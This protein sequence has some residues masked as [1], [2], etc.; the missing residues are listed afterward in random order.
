MRAWLKDGWPLLAGG[1]TAMAVVVGAAWQVSTRIGD[2][3]TRLHT[4]IGNVRNEVRDV[5]IR[6]QAE[7]G[8]VRTEVHQL[9]TDFESRM[10][11]VEAKLDILIAGLDIEVGP[12]NSGDGR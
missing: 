1:G 9:R 4:E 11:S 6:L 2:V 3:E 12:R 5:E 7:I 8:D 10:A